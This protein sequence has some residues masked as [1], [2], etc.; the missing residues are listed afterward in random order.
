MFFWEKTKQN[1]SKQKTKQNKEKQKQ[2][3]NKKKKKNSTALNSGYF[4]IME[5]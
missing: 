2:K 1:K 5:L 3:Q 4:F